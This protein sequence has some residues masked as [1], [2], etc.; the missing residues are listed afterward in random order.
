MHR[1]AQR[2]QP[3]H[4][5]IP[6]AH[7]HPHIRPEGEPGKQYR[8]VTFLL[9]PVER[10]AHV[11]L[12]AS[13]V[14]VPAFAQPRPAKIEAQHRQPQPLESLHS[15]IDDFVVQRSAAQ[16]VRMAHQ[17]GIIRLRSASVE[18]GLQTAF[19][20][21]QIFNCSYRIACGLR[22]THHSAIVWNGPIRPARQVC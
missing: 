17:H 19:G 11:V 7:S 6:A 13:A 20:P 1:K 4:P 3:L 22:F 10:R 14:V 21:A 18:Q 15:V 16:R 5:R 8:Q 2:Y 9:E 12:L